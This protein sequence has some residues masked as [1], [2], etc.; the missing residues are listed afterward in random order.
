M[1][2]ESR[3]LEIASELDPDEQPLRRPNDDTIFWRIDSD[4]VRHDCGSCG[5]PL[6]LGHMPAQWDGVILECSQC[7]AMNRIRPQV[8][9]I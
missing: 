8:I 5:E 4:K 6:A 7:K 2:W 1:D 3:P 9:E